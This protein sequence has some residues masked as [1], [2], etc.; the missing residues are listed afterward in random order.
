MKE[1]RVA[2]EGVSRVLKSP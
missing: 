1:N 2:D